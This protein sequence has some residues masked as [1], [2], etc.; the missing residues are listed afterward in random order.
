MRRLLL[1]FSPGRLILAAS[2]L[3]VVYL[4]VSAGGNVL[5]SYRLADD[6]GRLRQ[7]VMRLRYQ[8]QQIEQIRDY[9]RSDEYVE[10]MARR[11]FGLV[12]PG[13]TLVVITSTGPKTPVPEDE[14]E[15]DPGRPWWERLFGR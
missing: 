1:L 2:L 11:V 9:L 8:E 14:G 3:V 15:G 13:E 6:E 10:F 5:E 12:K 4:L 7:E